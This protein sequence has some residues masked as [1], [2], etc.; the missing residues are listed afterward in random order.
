MKQML[1]VTMMYELDRSTWGTKWQRPFSNYLLSLFNLI[2]HLQGTGHEIVVFGSDASVERLCELFPHA[3][4]MHKRLEDFHMFKHRGFLAK[5]LGNKF[6]LWTS[7]EFTRSEYIALQQSKFEA[8][9]IALRSKP[10][11][12]VTWIDGG[13]RH[14]P[15]D[16]ANVWD[17]IET[18][19]F[20]H[21]TKIWGCQCAQT[22]ASRWLILNTPTQQVQGSVWGGTAPAMEWLCNAA[23]HEAQT[24]VQRGE[25]ANDQQLLSLLHLDYPERFTLRKLYTVYVPGV[26]SQ[27]HVG[28]KKFMSTLLHNEDIVYHNYTLL[29]LL[30]V[31]IGLLLL[32]KASRLSMDSQRKAMSE[33]INGVAH[34]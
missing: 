22:I 13:I 8:V 25:V 30:A 17:D 10:R 4:Y 2:K 33:L 6:R 7:P 3:T 19:M 14:S 18:H 24:L 34:L 28:H 32:Y 21:P 1:F 26:F 31:P 5:A 29:G 15:Y 20:S 12:V 23:L 11:A 9:L 27:I 16:M